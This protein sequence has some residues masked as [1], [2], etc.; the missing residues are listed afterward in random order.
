MALGFA[1]T[2]AGASLSCCCSCCGWPHEQHGSSSAST[3]VSSLSPSS[4]SSLSSPNI[5]TIRQQQHTSSLPMRMV[6]PRPACH[7][8]RRTTSCHLFFRPTRTT[9]QNNSSQKSIIAQ[10]CE[11]LSTDS[12]IRLPYQID[13][14]QE[15]ETKNCTSSSNCSSITT[16]LTVRLA[17]SR[18]VASI[19]EMCVREYGGASS[20]SSSSSS[21]LGRRIVD[22]FD[23][24]VLYA[25]VFGTTLVKISEHP[26]DHA[27]LVGCVSSSNNNNQRT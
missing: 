3:S 26:E 1:P 27:V 16:T 25:L 23:Q 7:A 18:D 5:T 22:W 20:S 15:D 21:D 9:T 14:R 19:A 6:R 11:D 12:S 17:Q 2:M 4:A 8:R 13:F 10:V 24:R